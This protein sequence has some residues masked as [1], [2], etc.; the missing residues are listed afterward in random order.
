MKELHRDHEFFRLSTAIR[1]ARKCRQVDPENHLWSRGIRRRLDWESMRDSL[2]F[3]SGI[4]DQTMGGPSVSLMTEP[5]SRRRSVYGFI[6]R[7]SLPSVFRTFDFA[8]PDAS[9]PQ[10]FETT[11]PQ[12]ALF[13][14]NSPFIREIVYRLMSRSEFAFVKTKEERIE[15]IFRV[16][17]ARKPTSDEIRLASRYLES[18]PTVTDKISSAIGEHLTAWEELVQALLLSN[19]FMF[20]D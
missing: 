19:E 6:D 12:Q 9:S 3:V 13:L 14:M 10:R 5:F 18:E 4:L 11:V 8:S 20:V 1:N 15:A 7:Q 17:F 2:L 16:I